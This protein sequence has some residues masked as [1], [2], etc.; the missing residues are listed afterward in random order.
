MP[1]ALLTF[2]V[3]RVNAL[4]E[5][6]AATIRSILEK[7]LEQDGWERPVPHIHTTYKKIGFSGDPLATFRAAVAISRKE[8]AVT[9]GM[10]RVDYALMISPLDPLTGRL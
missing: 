6:E 3:R 8:T 1:N 4:Y 10:V 9:D 2:E 7:V 5:S